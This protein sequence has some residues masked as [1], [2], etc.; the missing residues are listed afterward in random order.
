MNKKDLKNIALMG[1]TSATIFSVGSAEA[2]NSQINNQQRY[3]GRNGCG[4]HSDNSDDQQSYD[5]QHRFAGRNGCG[6]HSDHDEDQNNDNSSYSHLHQ[7]GSNNHHIV[8]SSPSEQQSQLVSPSM[9][10]SHTNTS[11]SQNQYE[12]LEQAFY[13]ENGE[14]NEKGFVSQLSEESKQ[15]YNNLDESEKQLVL[16]MAKQFQDKN[17]ALRQAQKQAEIERKEEEEKE[18]E[19]ANRPRRTILRHSLFR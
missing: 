8:Y 18:Q 10:T 5:N 2:V 3:A 19:Q 17:N 6:G 14:I 1:I 15:V 11:N 16:R 7:T 13:S 9:S 4:G 12:V